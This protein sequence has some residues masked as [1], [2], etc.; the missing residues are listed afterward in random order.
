[1]KVIGWHAWYADGSKYDSKTTK[2]RDLPDDGVLVIVLYFNSK[3]PDGKHLRRINSGV[4]W[5]FRAKGLKDFIY[6][7][8]NDTPEENKKRYGE[9]ILLKRGKWADDTGMQRAEKE[10]SEAIDWL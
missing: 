3:R 7:Q 6:G 1:M 5:Y 2:W 8:N 9:D 4:D 10:A